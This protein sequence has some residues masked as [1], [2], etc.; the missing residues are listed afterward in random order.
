MYKINEE[1]KEILVVDD[2]GIN[3]MYD[4]SLQDM[5]QLE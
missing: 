5:Q 4:A 1:L 2:F 3:V